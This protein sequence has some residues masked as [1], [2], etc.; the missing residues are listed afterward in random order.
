MR[1]EPEISA[2]SIVMIGYFNP[3]IFQP[4]WLANHDIITE[5]EAE[6]ARVDFVHP[7]ITRFALEGEFTIQVE[8]DDFRLIEGSRH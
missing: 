1:I 5:D 2:V 7:D 4:F 3:Q 8:R 6:T